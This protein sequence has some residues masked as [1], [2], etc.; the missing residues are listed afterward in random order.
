MLAGEQDRGCDVFR[1]LREHNRGGLLVDRQIPS[2]PHFVKARVL[3]GD[4]LPV[5]CPSARLGGR[6]VAG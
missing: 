5:E 2:S 3:R 1:G 6:I 4:D